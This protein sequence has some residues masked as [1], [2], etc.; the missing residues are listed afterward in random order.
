MSEDYLDDFINQSLHKLHKERGNSDFIKSARLIGEVIGHSLHVV[1]DGFIEYRVRELIVN[2]IL[3]IKGVR[4][5]MRFYEVKF[6]SPWVLA[7]KD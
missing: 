6:R 1:G 4:K 5:A 2:G 3:D 7:G